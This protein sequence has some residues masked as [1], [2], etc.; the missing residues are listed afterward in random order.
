M[1]SCYSGRNMVDTKDSAT[2]PLSGA[3]A[4]ALTPLSADGMV[5]SPGG[6]GPLL[7]HLEAGGLDGVLVLGTTGEAPSLT[8]EEKKEIIAEA[9]ATHGRMKLLVGCGSC[10]LVETLQLVAFAARKQADAVLVPPPFYYRNVSLRGIEEYFAAVLDAAEL[11]VLLYHIPSHTGIPLDR[12]TLTRLSSKPRLW[13]VKDSGGKLSDTSRF[14]AAP[15]GRVL[16]GA[17][18]QILSG[19]KLGAQGVISACANI[20]PETVSDIWRK[21]RA[22]ENAEALQETV[23]A[24][25]EKLRQVPIYAAMKFLLREKGIDCG[26]VRLPLGQLTEEQEE[27]LRREQTAK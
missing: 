24:L 5:V 8:F 1:K 27:M 17:D 13:G 14:L 2:D 15:P 6:V 20:L 3:Y 4:A 19:L 12:G 11:P 23:A 21:Y 9:A 25:R 7:G 16:L 22:G 10:S 18:S 26:G